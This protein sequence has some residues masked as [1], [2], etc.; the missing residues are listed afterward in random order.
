MKLLV[1]GVEIEVEDSVALQSEVIKTCLEDC[2]TVPDLVP[3]P[4][5]L[6]P[7]L[8]EL[9]F[10]SQRLGGCDS[11]QLEI[12]YACDYLGLPFADRL[13][14]KLLRKLTRGD[15]DLGLLLLPDPTLL[16][17]LKT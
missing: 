10:E 1:G 4:L 11:Q 12:W 7:D 5:E 3:V 13:R 14:S 8:V 15:A 16:E 2:P 9:A 17:L 6:P